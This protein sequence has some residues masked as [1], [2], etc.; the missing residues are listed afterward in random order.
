MYV[1]NKVQILAWGVME[2]IYKLTLIE[3]QA[4]I[5]NVILFHLIK[6]NVSYN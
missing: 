4:L 2:K 5:T 3:K 6:K 1:C